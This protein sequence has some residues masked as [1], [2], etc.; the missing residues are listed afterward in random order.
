[1]GQN[2]VQF[3]RGLGMDEFQTLYGTEQQCI[4][5]V[6]SMRWPDGF[7]CAE[8]GHK[9]EYRIEREGRLLI[10]THCYYRTFLTAGTI[11]QDSK[12]SLRKW[13]LAMHLLTKDKQGISALQLMRELNVCYE[14]AW[15]LKQKLMAVMAERVQEKKLKGNAVADD[16]YVG[17]KHQGGKRGR[18][19]E[20]KIPVLA[21]LSLTDEGKPDQVNLRVVPGFTGQVIQEWAQKNL[22]RGLRL[23]TDGLACFAWVK[24]AGVEH[25]ST[26]MSQDLEQRDKGCFQWVNTIIGNLKMA[27]LGTYHHVSEKYLDRYL[28]EFEYRFNRRYDLKA[29]LPRLLYVALRTPPLPEPLLT[30]GPSY[31]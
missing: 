28:A 11:F 9:E 13:F 20:N 18:G 1:M 4:E 12:L 29:I 25:C 17:G 27:L 26:V 2:K 19:S 3:Q 23:F 7:E 15:T 22:A 31:R 5:A 8:C 14:T 24:E 21:A 6:H 30:L 10:C 16:L